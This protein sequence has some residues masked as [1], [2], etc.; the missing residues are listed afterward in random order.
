MLY[1]Q[2]LMGTDDRLHPHAK[3]SYS[4]QLKRIYLHVLR[5]TIYYPDQTSEEVCLDVLEMD[6]AHKVQ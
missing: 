5:L 3:H 1:L 6:V 4:R 2:R